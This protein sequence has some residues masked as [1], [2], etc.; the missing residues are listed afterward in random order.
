METHRF[1]G[2]TVILTARIADQANASEILV[3][4][5]LKQLTEAS[6]DVEFDDGRDVKLKGLADPHRLYALRWV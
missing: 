1:F 5:L 3:S 4:S 6:S 2:K